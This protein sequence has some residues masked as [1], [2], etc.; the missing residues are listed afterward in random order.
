M[1]SREPPF[2]DDWGNHVMGLKL[3]RVKGSEVSA[4]EVGEVLGLILVGL[5]AAAYTV[6]IK[7]DCN[8]KTSDIL[9][10]L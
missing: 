1:P 6:A 9:V 8:M 4:G 3:E 7:L 10:G 2:V 5:R